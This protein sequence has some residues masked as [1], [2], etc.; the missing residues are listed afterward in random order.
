MY[1]TPSICEVSRI[2]TCN[3]NWTPSIILSYNEWELVII[4]HHVMTRGSEF[5]QRMNGEYE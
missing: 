4:A 5:F 1:F 3:E 2:R